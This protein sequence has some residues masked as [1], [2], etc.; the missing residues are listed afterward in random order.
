MLSGAALLLAVSTGKLPRKEFCKHILIAADLK[1]RRAVVTHG[2]I[3]ASS[4][5]MRVVFCANMTSTECH[6]PSLV[7]WEIDSS[8]FDV[9]WT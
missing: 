2:S 1:W 4:S 5:K 7:L 9:L 6:A 3:Q 8:A